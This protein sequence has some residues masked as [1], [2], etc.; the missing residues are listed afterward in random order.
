MKETDVYVGE[1]DL[2][3]DPVS[4][5][6]KGYNCREYFT[7]KAYTKLR[8]QLLKSFR[9]D[10][11]RYAHLHPMMIMSV[12]TQSVLESDHGISLDEHLWDFAQQHQLKMQ[13]LETVEEQMSLLHSISPTPLYQQIKQIGARPSQIRKFTARALKYY[14]R[15]EIHLLYQ[16][17]RS[18]LHHLRKPIIDHR[19]EVMITRI[20]EYHPEWSYFI[21][22]GAGHLSGP[23]GLI[24]GLRKKGWRVIPAQA[25]MGS[26]NPSEE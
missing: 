22:V 9:L 20:S 10:I 16:M 7:S 4:M 26:G 18:S 11:D 2:S 23:K 12:I 19:N 17:T 15:G 5:P 1:M 6:D 21:T 14:T 25:H 13:G 24:S 3:A 8:N